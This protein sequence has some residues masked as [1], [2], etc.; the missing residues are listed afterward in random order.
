M[1]ESKFTSFGASGS[2]C[3][4]DPEDEDRKREALRG[5]GKFEGV[6]APEVGPLFLERSLGSE[7]VVPAGLLEGEKM[8]EFE[9]GQ[10]EQLLEEDDPAQDVFV[11]LEF[12]HKPRPS[13]VKSEPTDGDASGDPGVAESVGAAEV[14]DPPLRDEEDDKEG[15]TTR[16][17]LADKATAASRLH[18]PAPGPEEGVFLLVA[19]PKCGLRGSFSY[20]QVGEAIDPGSEPCARCFGRRPE[21][22][23]KKL[24]GVK[25]VVDGVE[26][27]CTRRCSVNCADAS[28]HLCHV[29]G[30]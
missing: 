30:Y 25:S 14:P 5:I 27:K 6:P 7:G 26:S 9:Q 15:L 16:L 28:V 29:H 11:E 17:V 10:L 1:G 13:V 2:E 12:D 3:G 23:C 18:L 8:M 20:V 24:C 22:A 19:A 4:P 21:G